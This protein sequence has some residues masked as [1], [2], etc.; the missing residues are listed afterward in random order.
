MRLGFTVVH[1]PLPD[2]RAHA[3]VLGENDKQMARALARSMVIVIS[4][5]RAV[6]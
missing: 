1:D 5:R 4:P 3:L 2:D 6:V